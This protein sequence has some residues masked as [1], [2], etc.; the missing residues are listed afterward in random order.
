[1]KNKVYLMTLRSELFDMNITD[2]QLM[3]VNEIFGNL[4]NANKIKIHK[5]GD[6]YKLKSQT[7]RI[8]S[9]RA[10]TVMADQYLKLSYKKICKLFESMR[11]ASLGGDDYFH[12]DKLTLHSD[13]IVYHILDCMMKRYSMDTIN[14]HIA[15]STRD[16][17]CNIAIAT[18]N[19]SY[20]GVNPISFDKS[21]ISYPK[22]KKLSLMNYTY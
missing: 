10:A 16:N 11:K 8:A 2:Y 9:H 1:M 20:A 5:V 13:N 3:R 12:Y 17:K 21:T 18:V 22:F 6:K 4:Y 14:L 15:A 7:I 19:I